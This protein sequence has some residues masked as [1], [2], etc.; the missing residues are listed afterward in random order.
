MERN[1]YYTVDSPED[2]RNFAPITRSRYPNT[3]PK[4]SPSPYNVAGSFI[5]LFTITPRPLQDKAARSNGTMRSCR[6]VSHSAAIYY[7]RKIGF[8]TLIPRSG[9]H[10]KM[11]PNGPDSAN[12]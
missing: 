4:A 6:L 1:T 7:T 10:S 12:R 9:V 2:A 5:N 8:K 11:V 3:P